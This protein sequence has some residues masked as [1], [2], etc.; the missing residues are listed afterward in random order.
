MRIMSLMTHCIMRIFERSC[1]EI[2]KVRR[3]PMSSRLPLDLRSLHPGRQV[4]GRL[5]FGTRKVF[6]VAFPKTVC[7]GQCFA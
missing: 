7:F 2:S 4:I 5:L 1:R 3:N 6:A